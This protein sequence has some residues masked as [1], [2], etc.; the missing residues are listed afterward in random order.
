MR[1]SWVVKLEASS[2]SG[3]GQLAIERTGS[4]LDVQR[5]TNFIYSEA[6]LERQQRLLSILQKEEVFDKSGNYFASRNQQYERS[7][8]RAKRL[9][10]LRIEHSWSDEDLVAAQE[11]IGET[12]TY[13]LHWSMFIVR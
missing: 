6:E 4:D 3:T 5:L 13:L 2:P 11:L 8:A 12:V 10:Q 7:L 9:G 1:P